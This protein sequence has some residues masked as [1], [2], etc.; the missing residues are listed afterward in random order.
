M[1]ISCSKKLLREI[2]FSL[3]NLILMTTPK[4][5]FQKN[6]WHYERYPFSIFAL[7]LSCTSMKNI[8][9]QKV[10][11]FMKKRLYV[12]A[13]SYEFCKI[14]WNNLFVQFL[15]ALVSVLNLSI[16]LLILFLI[17]FL[18]L[19]YLRKVKNNPSQI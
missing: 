4:L 12:S 18:T 8:L 6:A 2:S 16:I 9:R 10:Y 14:S 19:P 3:L 5:S 1:N 11:N 7:Y 15:L 17:V 13:L